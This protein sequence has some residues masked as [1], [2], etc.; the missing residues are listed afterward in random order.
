MS[1]L[2][3]DLEI[4]Q[5]GTF[6]LEKENETKINLNI[7]NV[8]ELEIEIVE[9]FISQTKKK[10]NI[11]EIMIFGYIQSYNNLVRIR[12]EDVRVTNGLN[13][14]DYNDTKN[15]LVFNY[16]EPINVTSNSFNCL[17]QKIYIEFENEIDIE[18]LRIVQDSNDLFQNVKYININAYS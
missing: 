14:K 10:C 7:F 12:I 11:N 8:K 16:Q 15:D 1:L 3:K 6:E 2:P 9:T 17:N 18:Y 4:V 13:V 5:L